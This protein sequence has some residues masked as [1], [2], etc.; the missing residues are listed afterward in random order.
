MSNKTTGKVIFFKDKD[1][2]FRFFSN[3]RATAPLSGKEG[4]A[5]ISPDELR[6]EPGSIVFVTIEDPYKAVLN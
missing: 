1:A 5:F 3:P 6:L 4:L 2:F